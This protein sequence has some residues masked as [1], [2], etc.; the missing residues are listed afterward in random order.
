MNRILAAVTELININGGNIIYLDQH[1]N[2]IENIL[3]MH[4]KW[5]LDGFVIPRE[6]IGEYFDTLF[7]AR[8]EMF[9]RIYFSDFTLRMA[10]F[11]SHMSYCRC[12]ILHAIRLGSGAWRYRLPSATTSTWDRILP[13]RH[14]LSLHPHHPR[15]PR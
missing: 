8:Y 9:L 12:N 6:K 5:E 1:A 13:L 2:R 3:F 10:I 4:V 14:T 15:N 7:A 11:V